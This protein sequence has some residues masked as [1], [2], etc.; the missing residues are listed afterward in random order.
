M[1]LSV[2]HKQAEPSQPEQTVNYYYK[3]KNAGNMVVNYLEQGT[4]AVLTA[5]KHLTEQIAW[6]AFTT[7]QRISN[8]FMTCICKSCSKRNLHKRNSDGQL[9]L[10]E[11]RRRD[12]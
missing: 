1:I 6:S 10:Q 4:N 12:V 7:V 8:Q 9:L 3:E 5:Q 11:K 2:S